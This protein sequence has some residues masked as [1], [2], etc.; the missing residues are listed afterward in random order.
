MQARL[1]PLIAE[2]AA[3][4][5][6]DTPW[7]QPART[8]LMRMLGYGRT[9]ALAEYFRHMPTHEIMET[10]T[11]L[12]ARDV[13]VRGLDHIPRQGPALIVANHPT[14]IADGIILH[15]ALSGLRSDAFYYA[16][17]DILRVLPQMNDVIV[18]AVPKA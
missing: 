12:L 3:W 5:F 15:H 1:D 16:N 2:R 14:G 6:D 4:L 13:V 10:M 11:G 7:A 8:A 17:S 18:P 9:L